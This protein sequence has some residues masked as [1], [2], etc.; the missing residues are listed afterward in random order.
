MRFEC[1]FSHFRIQT[2]TWFHPCITSS[3]IFRFTRYILVIF[4]LRF[5]CTSIRVIKVTSNQTDSEP[6]K[7]QSAKR[8]P[9]SK[10]TA[11]PKTMG[12]VHTHPSQQSPS[13][14]GS[15]D[16]GKQKQV[17]IASPVKSTSD[18]SS[19]PEKGSVSSSQG[20]NARSLLQCLCFTL[21]CYCGSV[22]QSVNNDNNGHWARLT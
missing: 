13:K 6:E 2:L 16:G 15:G 8:K 12:E 19:S 17:H 4:S 11:A 22:C 5:S 3:F 21:F 10:K 14:R 9:T 20:S 7:A 1:E 18:Y